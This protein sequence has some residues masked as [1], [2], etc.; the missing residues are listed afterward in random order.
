MSEI[1]LLDFEERDKEF[2]ASRSYKVGLCLTG[3]ASAPAEPIKFS[4]ESSIV[5]FQAEGDREIG[6]DLSV[7]IERFVLGGGAFVCFLGKKNSF[8]FAH[9]VGLPLEL[10]QPDGVYPDSVLFDS[11]APFHLV[12]ERFQPF[13]TYASKL[14]PNGQTGADSQDSGHRNGGYEVLARSSDGSPVSALFRK[15]KGFLLVLPWFGSKNLEVADCLL[16][17]LLPGGA[18]PSKDAKNNSWL[19]QEE[20]VFPVMKELLT[21]KEEENR[22][23]A[24]ALSEIDER[25]KEAREKDQEVFQ[26]LIRGEGPEL[27]N[28]VLHALDYLG[29]EKIVDVDEYWKNVIRNREEN[30][31]LIEGRENSVEAS[32][33]KDFF[34][35]VLSKEGKNGALDDEC[36]LL[37]KY[38]GR[39][40][41]E[42]DNTKMKAVLIGNYFST[43]EAKLRPNPYS[44]AQAEEAQKDG[45]GLLSTW[46]LFSAIK[47]EKEGRT[48]KEKIRQQIKE[49]T[50][51]ITFDL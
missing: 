51:L 32:M 17:E 50:G 36:S 15:G 16:K 42:F 5:F 40:M 47:A 49:K 28:A 30:I 6:Q 48:T 11:G 24:Q 25:I 18:S 43:Q 13:I 38:K 8:P 7:E 33:R 19:D 14:L 27:K 37:Q 44:T 1:L 41:Q 31:W 45:N 22:R 20:Y 21:Q 39:R 23:H 26:T 34:I 3:T 29:W 2:L 4:G 9:L 12:L 35:L 46:E 10:K